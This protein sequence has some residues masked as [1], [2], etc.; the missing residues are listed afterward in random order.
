MSDE[1]N[2]G[3]VTHALLTVRALTLQEGKA[4]V[5]LRPG[6]TPDEAAERIDMSSGREAEVHDYYADPEPHEMTVVAP[7]V[8]VTTAEARAFELDPEALGAALKK[9]GRLP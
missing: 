7:A 5:R 4:I 9:S 2:K 3:L 8:G 6:E 1:E